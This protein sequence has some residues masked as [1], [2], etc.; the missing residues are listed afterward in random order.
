MNQFMFVARD[1]NKPSV[2]MSDEERADFMKKFSAWTENLTDKKLFI[3]ADQLSKE[4]KRVQLND[5]SIKVVDGP[6]AETK[7]ALTGYF[8]IRA[9]NMDHAL[10]IAKT[11]PV[12]R[13]DNLE[14][15][16]IK[17]GTHNE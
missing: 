16:E 14:I 15:Y 6:F 12:L 13:F 2:A 8:L 10:E 11:C 4:F 5:A 7:E 17:E 3:R 1:K 9:E